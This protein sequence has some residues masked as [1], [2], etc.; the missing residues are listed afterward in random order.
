VESKE[1]KDLVLYFRDQIEDLGFVVDGATTST[2]RW[3][4]GNIKPFSFERYNI[5][6]TKLDFMVNAYTIKITH[7]YP[8]YNES[9][10]LIMYGSSQLKEIAIGKVTIY[11]S[12]ELDISN[13]NEL[14]E[15]IT[16]I[17]VIKCHL[18][19]KKL[20]RINGRLGIEI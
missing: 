15:Y 19:K 14:L 8:I 13:I 9:K 6:I 7:L 11:S 3:N 5:D 4:F 10:T 16:N 12:M 20:K 2:N 18:R 17:D 1:T